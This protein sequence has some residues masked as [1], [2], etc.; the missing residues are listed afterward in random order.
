MW[1]L[2]AIAVSRGGGQTKSFPSGEG[3]LAKPI[4]F[5]GFDKTDEEIALQITFVV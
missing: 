2:N 4:Y 5:K 1:R 3:G